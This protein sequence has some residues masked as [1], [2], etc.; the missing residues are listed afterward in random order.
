MND[1]EEKVVIP[2]AE[3]V[4]AYGGAPGGP[5]G[6]AAPP[7]ADQ[8]GAPPTA[9]A[10]AGATENDWREIA[11]RARAELSNYQKRS[12][13]DRADSIRYANAGL[14]KA[15]LPVLDNLERVIQTGTAGEAKI[16][17]L[18]DGVKLTLDQF[19][20]ALREYHVEMIP[21]EGQP[22]DPQVHEAMMERPSDHAERTVL[23]ELGKGYRLYDR[24]L[25]PAK[26][27]VSKP[28]AAAEAN[29]ATAIEESRMANESP[30]IKPE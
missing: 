15:L 2:S 28:T 9:P 14:L 8:A 4:A 29:Q 21:A 5:A 13:K 10:E 18:L 26:V 19:Q 30:V 6:N 1:A 7:E 16:Q 11:L 12:E 25:R 3:E 20:K 24:V 23:Q 22:F 17:A 27:I